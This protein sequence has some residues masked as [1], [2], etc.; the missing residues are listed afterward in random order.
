MFLAPRRPRLRVRS[1]LFSGC[2]FLFSEMYKINKV[3]DLDLLISVLVLGVG[4]G[5][6][7]TARTC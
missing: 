7:R 1:R 2:F 3:L 4:V 6:Q 5:E